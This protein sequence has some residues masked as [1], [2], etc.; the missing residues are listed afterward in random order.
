MSCVST[1]LSA[2]D[3]ALNRRDSVQLTRCYSDRFMQMSRG[4]DG[5]V[6]TWRRN[7]LHFRAGLERALCFYDSIGAA[8]FELFV[9]NKTSPQPAHSLVR[10]AWRV[11]RADGSELVTLEVS[12]MIRVRHT[13]PRIVAFIDH[14]EEGRLLARRRTSEPRQP[15]VHVGW[16]KGAAE[17]LS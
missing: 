2:Y 12:Y 17:P 11:R 6:H 16:S 5:W 7:D 10:V 9:L 14:D 1:L 13:E 8:N 15:L 4:I 3:A